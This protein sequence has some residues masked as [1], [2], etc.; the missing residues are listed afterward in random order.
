MIYILLSYANDK[1]TAPAQ[2]PSQYYTTTNRYTLI[3][4]NILFHYYIYGKNDDLIVTMLNSYYI[5]FTTI[6]YYGEFKTF[7]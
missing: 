4:L 6:S 7:S 1:V 5:I 3:K 2:L